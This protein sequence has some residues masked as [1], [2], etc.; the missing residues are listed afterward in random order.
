MHETGMARERSEGKELCKVG[1][2]KRKRERVKDG[3]YGVREK[4]K[5]RDGEGR[6]GKGR[7]RGRIK[8]G[9]RTLMFVES[10]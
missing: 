1:R 7:Q 6:K 10:V 3:L 9:L 5:G 8:I 4:R 2:A